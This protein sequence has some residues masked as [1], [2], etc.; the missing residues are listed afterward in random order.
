MKP[1]EATLLKPCGVTLSK[2]S[3]LFP[4]H[5]R[6]V[7]FFPTWIRI[8]LASDI[9]KGEVI[10]KSTIH[11]SMPPTLKATYHS[12]VKTYQTMYAFENHLHVCNVEKH[13]TTVDSGV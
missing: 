13:L 4:N 6:Q 11:M 12:Y 5:L 10:D 2:G 7:A 3:I 8:V 1:R 9:K